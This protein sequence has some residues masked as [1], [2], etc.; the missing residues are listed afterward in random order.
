MA[1]VQQETKSREG[2]SQREGRQPKEGGADRREERRS[3]PEG[4]PEIDL[5]KLISDPLYLDNQAH[6]VVS[7]M[8]D[9]DSGTK[10]QLRRL[11]NA[12][13]RA[14]RAPE[15][16]RQQQFVMLRARLAYTIARHSLRSLDAL[17]KLLLQV[18]RKNDPRGYE[19]FRDLFEAIV[20]YNE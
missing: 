15:N 14:C 20:A 18:T 13:R 8:R 9:M 5:D 2:R 19:R 11:Y 16:E 10:S 3:R 1:E 17:E 4:P 6:S 7:R 12:V